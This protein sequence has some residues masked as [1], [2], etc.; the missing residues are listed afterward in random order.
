[1]VHAFEPNPKLF[2]GILGI[3]DNVR[4]WPFAVGEDT[5][6]ETLHVPEGLSGWASLEDISKLVPGPTHDARQHRTGR[7]E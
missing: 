3:G 7:H 5:R 2:S 1:M 6:V 4:L